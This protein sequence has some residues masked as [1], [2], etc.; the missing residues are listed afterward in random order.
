MTVVHGALVARRGAAALLA[1]KSGAGKSTTA[2]ACALAGHD[3]L[4]DDRFILARGDHMT[5]VA[6]SLFATAQVSS[7]AL[8][9]FPQL[10]AGAPTVWEPGEKVVVALGQTSRVTCA[11]EARIQAILLPRVNGGPPAVRPVARSRALL[12]LAP[13]SLFQ[14]VGGRG[15]FERLAQLAGAVPAWQLELGPDLSAIAALVDRV[16]VG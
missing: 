13:S 16:L 6:Y 11:S 14:L 8:E 7:S 3:Y 1:G 2:L 12:A 4:A 5:F 9:R 10:R 15:G